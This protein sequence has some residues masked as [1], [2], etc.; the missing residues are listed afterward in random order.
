MATSATAVYAFQTA[1]GLG[2]V[3]TEHYARRLREAPITLNDPDIDLWPNS[4]RGKRGR[5]AAHVQRHHLRSFLLGLS[6]ENAMDAPRAALQLAELVPVGPADV[7]IITRRPH[8]AVETYA[9]AVP[10]D[11]TFPTLGELL[12]AEIEHVARCGAAGLA[13]GEWELLL[14]PGHREAVTS[15]LSLDAQG[16]L[17]RV[18]HKYAHPQL[19]LSP[20]SARLRRATIISAALLAEAGRLWR[21]TLDRQVEHLPLP[22]PVS[23]TGKGRGTPGPLSA[24]PAREKDEGPAPARAGPSDGVAS[25]QREHS[26]WTTGDYRKP[27]NSREREIAPG[28]GRGDGTSGAAP[29]PRGTAAHGPPPDYPAAA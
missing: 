28:G 23:A 9:E 17:C 3:A 20:A 11:V 24:P 6:V 7:E 22:K 8:G 1:T 26:D 16:R 29:N 2:P 12:D 13:A 18:R 15:R 10:Y 27:T 4:G 21:D 5:A 19:E 25:P 14:S